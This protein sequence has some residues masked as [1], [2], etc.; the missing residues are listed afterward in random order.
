LLASRQRDA[1][2]NHRF[3]SAWSSMTFSGARHTATNRDRMT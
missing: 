2:G 1:A 3:F